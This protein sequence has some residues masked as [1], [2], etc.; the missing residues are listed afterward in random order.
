MSEIVTYASFA[1]TAIGII[2]SILG[3][4]KS[5]KLEHKFN[6]ERQIV[7]LAHLSACEH[8]MQ[9]LE[10]RIQASEKRREPHERKVLDAIT[11][12]L[13]MTVCRL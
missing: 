10:Q 5:Q 1:F 7:A 3:I 4:V 13:E 12:L 2:I 8:E 6:K 9:L 11:R